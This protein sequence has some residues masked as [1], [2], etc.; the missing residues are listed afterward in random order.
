[1]ERNEKQYSPVYFKLQNLPNG[2]TKFGQVYEHASKIGKAPMQFLAM[3]TIEIREGHP[4]FKYA[5]TLIDM[6]TNYVFTIPIKDT[7][8]KTLVHEYI[9]KL[10]LPFGRTEKF[11][12]DNGT[13]FIN[14]DW[15]NLANALAF[16][17]FQSSPRNPRAKWPNGKCA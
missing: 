2:I 10:F 4:T 7:C 17:H 15:R 16:K 9:Y 1:M 14:E 13:S 5:F 12:L 6:L 8:G 11:L 3:D